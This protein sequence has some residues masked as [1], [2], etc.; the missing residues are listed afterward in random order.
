MMNT[1]KNPR[2]FKDM[3]LRRLGAPVIQVEVTE[4]HIY[5]CI[6]RS[7]ELY[8]EYH[9]DALN[10][11]YITVSM[12]AEQAATGHID[13]SAYPIFSVNKILR[14]GNTLGSSLGGGTSLDFM[15]NFLQQLGGSDG[16]G[17]CSYSGPLGGGFG[18]VGY[19]TQLSSYQNM[20]NDQ[21]NP[22]PD[23]WYD[24]NNGVIQITGDY[25]QG[26]FFIL[27]VFIQSFVDLDERAIIGL[28]GNGVAGCANTPTTLKDE[29]ID[30]YKRLK[31]GV[32]GQCRSEFPDQGVYNVRWVKDY[33]TALTKE[34][35]GEILAKHQGMQLPGGVTIDGERLI[36]EAKQEILDLRQELLLL[37]E[38]LPIMMG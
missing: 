9:Y 1:V 38:P 15:N 21:L 27:E 12:S 10:K 17:E 33:A 2:E 29:W 37:E 23:Y 24:S 14:S 18:N 30:P 13:L 22:I 32:A 34:L 16:S 36:N 31:V 5:D 26:D 20:M 3:I 6:G 19:F 25:V 7:L 35:W 8:K 28:A 11:A 4:D